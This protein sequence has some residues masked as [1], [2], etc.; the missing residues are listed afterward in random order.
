MTEQ[1]KSVAEIRER[2]DN[3]VDRF[4]NAETGQTSTVDS[5][6]VMDLMQDAIVAVNPAMR[7]MC[8]VGCG[9][10]NWSVR[11][12]RR[13]P[14]LAV[15]LVDLSAPMLDRASQRV[16]E[17][18]G[19]VE[20]RIQGDIREVSLPRAAFD[21]V[22]AGAVLHHLRSHDEWLAVAARIF[23]ALVPGGTF[24]MWDLVRY[25]NPAVQAIQT[26]RY[27]GYL[28]AQG[29]EEYARRIF[30]LIEQDDTPETTEFIVK[31]LQEAGFSEVEIIHKNTVFCALYARKR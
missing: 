27:A 8:D 25:A 1:K 29:G 2:F 18:G 5:A 21:A 20:A 16:A 23:D 31:T 12:A 14:G 6:L 19:H 30:E 24:W 10:G 28:V 22:V 3:D 13:V 11:V 17:A 4:S 26:R 15:T 9:G 7:R